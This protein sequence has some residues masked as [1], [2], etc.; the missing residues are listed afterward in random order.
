MMIIFYNIT[1][2]ITIIIIII[3]IIIMIIIIIIIIIITIKTIIIII[4]II[5]I[6]IITKKI[7]ITHVQSRPHVPWKHNRDRRLGILIPCTLGTQ[8][9]GNTRGID[10]ALKSWS[11]AET[12]L[13]TPCTLEHNPGKPLGFLK[14]RTLETQARSEGPGLDPCTRRNTVHIGDGRLGGLTPCNPRTIIKRD[15]AGC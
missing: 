6:T 3:I 4:I 12:R 10:H 2:I 14:P 13:L 8:S 1:T 11:R 15:T 9:K 5:T 7:I